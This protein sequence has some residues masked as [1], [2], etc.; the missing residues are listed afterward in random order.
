MIRLIIFL[1]GAV[2][3]W[4]LFA[5]GFNKRL[6]II[7]SLSLLVILITGV[8]YENYGETPRSDLITTEQIVSCGVSAKHSYRS[9]YKINYCLKNNSK[10]ATTKRLE[11]RFV[12]YDCL[13]QPCKEIESVIKEGNFEIAPEQKIKTEVSLAFDSLSLNQDNIEWKVDVVSVKAVK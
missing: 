2:L 12:A 4:I 11:L 8:W 6:K 5:S 9:D 13:V 7:L 10:V 1:I 3:L